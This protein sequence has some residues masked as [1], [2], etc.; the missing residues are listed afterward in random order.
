MLWGFVTNAESDEVRANEALARYFP[1][2]DVDTMLK[3]IRTC[4][5]LS[6]RELIWPIATLAMSLTCYRGV[7]GLRA[8]RLISKYMVTNS[9]IK[10]CLGTVGLDMQVES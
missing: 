5:V 10:D 2:Q 9:S 3:A 1:S 4:V 7:D 8:M 6:V